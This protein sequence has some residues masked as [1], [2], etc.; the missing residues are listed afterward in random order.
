MERRKQKAS[1]PIV[2]GVRKPIECKTRV[3]ETVLSLVT[4]RCT[5]KIQLKLEMDFDEI[6]RI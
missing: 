1:Y 6:S 4:I 5:K 3:M 2:S